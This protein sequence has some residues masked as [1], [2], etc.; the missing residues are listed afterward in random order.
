MER[1]DAEIEWFSTHRI[2]SVLCCDANFGMLP[3]DLDI[4]QKIVDAKQ[5]TGFPFSFM[6]QNAKNATE[7]SYQIQKLI[8][9]SMQ[10]Y[11]G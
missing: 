8:N 3:R 6:I 1:L 7:R 9:D 5:R 4:A 2:G 11:R 10:N